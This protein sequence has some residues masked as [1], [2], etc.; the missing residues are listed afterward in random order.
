MCASCPQSHP[1]AVAGRLMARSA[2]EGENVTVAF[3]YAGP[4]NLGSSTAHAASART[5]SVLHIMGKPAMV[6]MSLSSFQ[7]FLI[8]ALLPSTL[9]S[10]RE[11]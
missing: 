8:T 1:C 2:V 9:A 10:E 7:S 4:Q 3:A 5:G 11:T 6:R